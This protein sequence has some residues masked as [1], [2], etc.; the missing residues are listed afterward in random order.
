MSYKHRHKQEVSKSKI[1]AHAK[2]TWNENECH[3]SVGM[4][5]T[6]QHNNLVPGILEEHTLYHVYYVKG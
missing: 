2:F 1:I 3:I 6:R 5:D 4:V